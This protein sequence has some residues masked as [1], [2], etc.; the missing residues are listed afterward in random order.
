MNYSKIILVFH[1]SYFIATLK[2]HIPPENCNTLII[3]KALLN[4]QLFTVQLLLLFI[5]NTLFYSLFSP[6]GVYT[7]AE[8]KMILK[9]NKMIYSIVI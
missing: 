8:T 3:P 2:V 5:Y 6:I 7:T 1:N 4:F 9:G